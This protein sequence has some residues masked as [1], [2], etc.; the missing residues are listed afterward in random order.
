MNGNDTT[1]G[2]DETKTRYALEILR[3]FTSP[4]S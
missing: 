3:R 4:A 2:G 1:I